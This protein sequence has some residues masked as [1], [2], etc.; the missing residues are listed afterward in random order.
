MA[1]KHLVAAWSV[2]IGSATMAAPPATHVPHMDLEMTSAEYRALFDRMEREHHAPISS[3]LGL[4]ANDEVTQ[5]L[6]FGKRLLDWTAAINATRPADQQLLLSTPETQAAYPIETPRYSNPEIILEKLNFIRPEMPVEM[7]NL[8]FGT[9]AIPT[10]TT[11]DNETFVAF[12]RPFTRIYEA[13]SRWLLQSPYLDEYASLAAGDI[14]GYYF[15]AQISDLPTKL[16][17]WGTLD[18]ATQTQWSAWLEGE[19]MNAAVA[20]DKCYTDLAAAI[21]ANTIKD[22]HELYVTKAKET[23]DHFFKLE[24]ARPDITWNAQNPNVLAADFL[25]PAD[26]NIATWLA[27]NIEDEWRVDNWTLKLAFKTEGPHPKIEFVAGATP[28]VNDLGGDTV[29]MDANRPLTDY[30]VRWTIRHEYGHVLGFPDCYIE[31]YDAD[32]QMMVSY[33]IDITNLMCSRRGHLQKQ[34][35]DELRRAYYH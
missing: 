35:V 29:T 13:A 21:T 16:A 26:A 14:R 33:Q 12:A 10:T 34:H 5:I 24:N 4:N 23:F 3:I 20:K 22:F 18:T 17:A 30:N 6:D 11:I 15:L 19:C 25:Q 1:L 7:S 32:K 28:H 9:A 2:C 8:I 27:T 31:F